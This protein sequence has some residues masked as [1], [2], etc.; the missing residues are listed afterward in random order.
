MLVSHGNGTAKT[1][2]LADECCVRR[3]YQDR[4]AALVA[5]YSK[6]Y[7]YVR[8]PGTTSVGFGRRGTPDGRRSAL[9]SFVPPRLGPLILEAS[10]RRNVSAALLAAQLYAESGLNPFAVSPAG[11]KGLAQFMPGTAHSYGLGLLGGA[12]D[13]AMPTFGL[14]LVE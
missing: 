11:A 7:G 13:L 5:E 6:H 14:H 9:P 8:N 4:L 1:R 10:Q 12:G 3:K 2:S